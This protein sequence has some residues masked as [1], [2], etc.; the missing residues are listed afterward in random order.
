MD[1]GA[2]DAPAAAAAADEDG[3]DEE[4]VRPERASSDL[5]MSRKRGT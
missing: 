3:D 1:D 5:T 2:P 4:G